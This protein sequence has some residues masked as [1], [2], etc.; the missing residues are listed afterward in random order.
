MRFFDAD[1]GLVVLNILGKEKTGMWALR[2][3][4]GGKT[5]EEEELPVESGMPYLSRDGAFLAVYTSDGR[6]ITLLHYQ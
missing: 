1:H 6:E 3:A 4:D 2:T 5:W